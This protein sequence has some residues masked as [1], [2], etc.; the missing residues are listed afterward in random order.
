MNRHGNVVA[1]SAFKGVC[2]DKERGRYRAQIKANGRRR[3]IGRFATEREA[4]KAYNEEAAKHFGE[5]A[6]LNP[7]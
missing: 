7:L 1:T 6:V 5:F 2:Y 4:A 3:L